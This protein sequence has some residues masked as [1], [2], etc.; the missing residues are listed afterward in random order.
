MSYPS[1]NHS[2]TISADFQYCADDVD[3]FTTLGL[4]H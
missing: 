2:A 4:L 1:L 3:Y